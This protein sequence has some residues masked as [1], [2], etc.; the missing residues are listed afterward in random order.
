MII[1]YAVLALNSSEVA[2]RVCL[3]VLIF[4]ILL[5]LLFPFPLLRINCLWKA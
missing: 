4:C 5:L 2:F 3:V 1:C